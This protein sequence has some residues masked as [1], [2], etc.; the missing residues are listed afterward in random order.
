MTVSISLKPGKH[1]VSQ[2]VST[3]AMYSIGITEELQLIFGFQISKLR[4]LHMQAQPKLGFV[5]LGA[6]VLIFL[7]KSLVDEMH[8]LNSDIPILHG[9]PILNY[10][11]KD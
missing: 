5:Q 9:N 6:L 11:S 8:G 7:R 4:L 3:P 10:G 2:S 1:E